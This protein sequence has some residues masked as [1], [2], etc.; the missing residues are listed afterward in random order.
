[1]RPVLALLTALSALTLSLA[2]PATARA[3]GLVIILPPGTH[4]VDPE[5]WPAPGPG[6]R[7]PRLPAP[8]R[9]EFFPLSVVSHH[10]TVDVLGP[11][12]ST[13]V[14]QVFANPNDRD[15]EGTYIFPLPDGATVSKF[16][17]YMNGKEVEAELLDAAKARAIYEGIVR[18]MQDPGL[19]EYAGKGLV[20]ARLYPIPA[21]GTT[22]VKIA[23]QEVLRTDAGLTEVRYPLSTEKWSA[24]PL[25]E[26]SVTVRIAGA[27]RGGVPVGRVY[28]PSHPIDVAR[29]RTPGGGVT[30]RWSA[31]NALPDRDF[32]LLFQRAEAGRVLDVAMITHRSVGED[33]WF[34]MLLS[35]PDEIAE[36][37]PAPKDVVFVVDTSGSMAGAKMT[38]A[39][40]A[41]TYCVSALEAQD[42]FTIVD[43]ATEVRPWKRELVPASRDAVAEALARVDALKA[44][45][46]TDI[47]GALTEALGVKGT[48]G[49]PFLVVFL[50]DGEPTIGTTIPSEIEKAVRS[51]REARPDR[52]D[53]RL[54]VFGI[55]GDLNAPLL[56]RL[57][58]QGKGAREYVAEGESIELKVSRFFDKV[59]AP[60]FSDVRV[61]ASGFEIYDLYP[62]PIPDLF[63]G[64]E[65]ALIGRY[66]TTQ[67]R[68]L[69]GIRIQGKVGGRE[70]EILA[71]AHL[72]DSASAPYLPRLHAVRKVGFLLDQARLHGETEEV[73]QEIV[74]LAKEHGIVTPY[75]SWLVVEDERRISQTR[76]GGARHAAADAF[77]GLMQGD[78]GRRLRD[79][80]EKTIGLTRTGSGGGAG[81]SGS[82]GAPPAAPATPEDRER[83]IAAGE[84]AKKMAEASAASAAATPAQG[85]ADAAREMGRYQEAKKDGGAAKRAAEE[86]AQ[87]GKAEAALQDAV[88][89]VDGRAFYRRGAQWVDARC[90]PEAK[91]ARRI[92]YLSEAYFKLI[93]D[94]PALGKVLSIGAEIRLQDGAE[95]IE[96]TAEEGAG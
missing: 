17:L 6:P 49:R 74:R 32:S 69:A 91:A 70:V 42:R 26:A 90:A 78:G 52:G 12:A 66:R 11:V 43:F 1:M 20:K 79:E 41:L 13:E 88:R 95:V 64:G 68:G 63:R 58:E 59:A 7:P 72:S 86:L 2:A 84:A 33:G 77:E 37:E 28:S 4:I 60:A 27:D 22:R 16:S 19:L 54:F 38:Q 73:R 10:V 46:G 23:Y 3:D 34:M 36:G 96:I 56:D 45:G 94:R 53:V 21:R 76:P 14:D 9:R 57:A 35:P 18:R 15:L 71:P 85:L 8:P 44:R 83:Q 92:A 30:V 87:G 51:A 65:V 89:L 31:R 93:A 39:K 25:A 80:A 55:G 82:K 29:E 75:T 48:P 61:L 40:A 50:T 47:C 67:L 5:P 62:R 81:A 24:A